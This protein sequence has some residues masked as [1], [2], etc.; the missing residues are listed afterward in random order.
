MKEIIIPEDVYVHKFL[1]L[2]H[3][4]KGYGEN[5]GNLQKNFGKIEENESFLR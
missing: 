3:L 2:N 5:M 4:E 1:W